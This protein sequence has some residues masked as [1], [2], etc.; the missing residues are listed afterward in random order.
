MCGNYDPA[1]LWGVT[2]RRWL[3][4]GEKLTGLRPDPLCWEEWDMQ[5]G[6]GMRGWWW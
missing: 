6:E 1:L 4:P 3:Q 2:V 5:V